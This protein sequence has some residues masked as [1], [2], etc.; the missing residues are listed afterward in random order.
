MRV[1]GWM[2]WAGKRVLGTAPGA[3]G[4]T[5]SARF[6]VA[7]V[8]GVSMLAAPGAVR[9]SPTSEC[10]WAGSPV[11]SNVRANKMTISGT[12]VRLR[13]PRDFT[14]FK[15]TLAQCNAMSVVP[16]V[17]AWQ[18]AR[19][20]ATAAALVATVEGAS[21][22]TDAALAKSEEAQTRKAVQAAEQGAQ[23]AITVQQLDAVAK[24]RRD[25][26]VLALQ[27]TSAPTGGMADT[28]V[29]A[30]PEASGDSDELELLRARL[31]IEQAKAETAKA[32]AA[33]AKA[34]AAKAS[35]E[36]A[37]ARAEADAGRTRSAGADG[38]KAT[39]GTLDT[40]AATPAADTGAE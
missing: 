5:P 30:M 29:E 20:E 15:Q 35:A 26:V 23:N 37:K 34:E 14:S 38:A 19:Q 32:E 11:I 33:R 4:D 31:A 2:R 40:G 28:G 10:P 25:D 36:A 12:E 1:S 24:A 13:N 22:A 3:G 7:M 6:P 18:A 9:G 16:L 39:G 17:T 27:A 8:V 21:S